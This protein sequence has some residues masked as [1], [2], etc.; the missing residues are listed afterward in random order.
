MALSLV[1]TPVPSVYRPR[2]GPSDLGVKAAIEVWHRQARHGQPPSDREGGRRAGGGLPSGQGQ[3]S[4]LPHRHVLP[5][6]ENS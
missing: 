2:A 3:F 5:A 1:Q 6:Q 4:R